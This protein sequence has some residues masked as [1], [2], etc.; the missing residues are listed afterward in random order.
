MVLTHGSSLHLDITGFEGATHGRYVKV[1]SGAR[2]VMISI[3]ELK[4]SANVLAER[5]SSVGLTITPNDSRNLLERISRWTDWKT[6]AAAERSG[7]YGSAYVMPDGK[8]YQP[9]GNDAP[10]DVLFTPDTKRCSQRGSFKRWQR[11]IAA[12]LEGSPYA[13]FALMLAFVAPL[14]KLH[15]RENNI[16]F[17]FSGD[18]S[19][20]KSIV[21][22]LAASVWGP[23]N[24]STSERYWIQTNRTTNAIER[25]AMNHPD[26]FLA[27]DDLENYAK[28]KP[29]RAR[30]LELESLIFRLSEGESRDRLNGP[31]TLN[32]RVAALLS[33]NKSIVE[34]LNDP[35]AKRN[36]ATELRFLTMPVDEQLDLKIFESIP[37]KLSGSGEFVEELMRSAKN[38]HGHPIRKFVQGL[39]NFR[40][41]H[42]RAFEKRMRDRMKAFY[43]ALGI[44][45]SD[46]VRRR[47][48]EAFGLVAIAGGLAKKFGILP[49]SYEPSKIAQICYE[50]H[51]IVALGEASIGNTLSAFAKRPGIIDLDEGYPKLSQQELSAVPGFL[52]T[53]LKGHNPEAQFLIVPET[54]I[55]HLFAGWA[56]LKNSCK[57][58]GILLRE[59]RRPSKQVKVH[60]FG[61][62]RCCVF[63]LK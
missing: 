28:D 15:D 32:F 48:A 8:A 50:R 16:L 5:L 11:R 23:I 2:H 29:E 3:A 21:M 4:S 26:A 33:S 14:L 39:V 51:A 44:D 59:G 31:E 52:K 36:I 47:K 20:G 55:R 61:K 63:R 34:L 37:H 6:V 18:S 12:R 10:I 62:V 25:I 13:Q 9:N 49:A 19:V 22:K 27:V 35:S 7:W 41:K 17:E 56:G 54:R 24:G 46:G 40:H 43:K 45:P 42:E 57:L 53:G 1:G 30:V 38:N 58:D 60:Q